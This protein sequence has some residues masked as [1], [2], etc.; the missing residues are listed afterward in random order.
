MKTT[1]SEALRK[2]GAIFRRRRL[3][4]ELDTELATRIEMATDDFMQQVLSPEEARRRALV[5]LGGIEQSKETQRDARSLPAVET[6]LQDARYAVRTL[7]RDTGFALFTT[8]IIGLGV[9]A[10]ATVFSVVNSLLVRP[11]PIKDPASLVWLANKVDTED[12]IRLIDFGIAANA[13]SRRL[14]FANFSRNMGTPDYISPEQVR[15]KRGDARSDVYALGVM[16]YE[17]LTGK[18]PFTGPNAFAVMNDR[19]VNQPVPPRNLEPAIS[20]QLQEIVYR[21]LEREPKN[22]YHTAHEFAH[23]LAH[24][25]EV[26]VTAR[27]KE[28]N[29]EK[30]EHPGKRRLLLYAG[31][32]LLPAAIF[33]LLYLV[34][35]HR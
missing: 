32:A 31:L 28:A 7:R 20:P 17:M 15:G 34:A 23:D 22:R 9:G 2:L 10:S 6:I 12:N 1:L 11:L 25:E 26:G 3:D 24:P 21:A 5:K 4:S 27:V 19:L 8:L 33:L 29:W 35:K 14:P 18:V 16:L 30:R 13:G